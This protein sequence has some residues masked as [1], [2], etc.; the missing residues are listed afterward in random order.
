MFALISGAGSVGSYAYPLKWDDPL[1][2][3]QSRA[4]DLEV[5]IRIIGWDLRMVPVPLGY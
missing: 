3:V 2:D 1:S 4:G 5:L